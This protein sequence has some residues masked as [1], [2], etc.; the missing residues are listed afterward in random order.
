[1]NRK[2]ILANES[3]ILPQKVKVDM[4]NAVKVKFTEI[5]AAMGFDQQNDPNLK[6]TPN[7]IAKMY[8]E[9]LFSGCFNPPPKITVFPN[10]QGYDQIVALSDISIKSTC[11]HHFCPF[12]GT[13][14]IGYIPNEKVVGL[15]KLSRIADYFAR[16][17]QIQEELTEQIANYIEEILQP[18]GVIVVIK[19]EHHCMKLR[20]V[21]EHEAVMT[22]SALRGFF[23]TNA[24]TKQEF[25]ELIRK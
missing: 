9:E 13:A 17:P 22:T 10:T 5:L 25:F 2:K 24:S 18:K 14:S 8:V 19:A 21:Q 4:T 7:R 1:M 11:S 6:D 15:S 20:G 23:L 3:V 16:R 12:L